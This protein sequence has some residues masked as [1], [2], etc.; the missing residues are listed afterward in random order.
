M[1][2]ARRLSR[3]LALQVLFQR[4]F[5][6]SVDVRSNLANFRDNFAASDDV[7]NYTEFLLTGVDT[8]GPAIDALIQK[9]SA[10]WTMQRM[11]LVD[12]NIMRIAVFETKFASEPLPPAVAINEAVE[13]SKKFGTNDSPS[14]VN[15]ILDQIVK[16]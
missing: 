11:A 6:P 2:S 3:E 4:E 5:S 15:G 9:C 8:H 14:F 13:I 12:R 1:T 7:W 10:H 16:Q